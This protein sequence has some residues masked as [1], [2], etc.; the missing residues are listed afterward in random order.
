MS[1]TIL[2]MFSG[3]L[4]STGAFWKLIENQEKIHVHHMNLKN[5]ENR[6]LAEN[7]AT[8]NIIEY[9]K[10]IADFSYSESTHEYESYNNKF[11]WDSD[12][13]SFMAGN[14]CSFIPSIKNIALGLTKSDLNG[15]VNDRIARGNKILEALCSATKIYPIKH[16]TKKEVWDFLPENLRK[17]SWS[18]RNPIYQENEIISCRKCKTCYEMDK[19]G[20]T[21]QQIHLNQNHS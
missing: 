16:L 1:P 4:D 13:S 10:N 3:G 19:V 14:I 15:S 9:M 20:I 2:L 21:L 11:I 7:I 18:C 12:L 17:L 8:K 6:Y 5:I